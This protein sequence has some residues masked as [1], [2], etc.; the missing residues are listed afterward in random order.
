M[1]MRD[2][3]HKTLKDDDS[4]L[5][6]ILKSTKVW[7][8]R[9]FIAIHRGSLAPS[10]TLPSKRTAAATGSCV[11]RSLCVCAT[12]LVTLLVSLRALLPV[13]APNQALRGQ[14]SYFQVDLN[15]T[16]ED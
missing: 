16:V 10:V 7:Q 14:C 11:P 12:V 2:D 4:T 15:H 13:W 6:L 1:Q 8:P 3:W 5:A 9:P